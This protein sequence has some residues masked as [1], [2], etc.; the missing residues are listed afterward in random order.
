[1]ALM[2]PVGRDLNPRDKIK[3][4][5]A[6]VRLWHW[7]N[8]IAN[9]GLLLTVLIV[10]TVTNRYET[11]RLV[12]QELQMAKVS[13][14]NDQAKQVAQALGEGVWDVHVHFGYCL[15]GLLLFRLL[16]EAFQIA[17]QKLIRKIKNAYRQ[18]NIVNRNGEVDRHELAEMIIYVIFYILLIIQSVT[19]LSIT[20]ENIA[21]VKLNHSGI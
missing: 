11:S 21:F 8:A 5:S 10:S 6:S 1:M 3:K 19:G 7:T 17:D 2:E 4:H 20:F 14:N 16:L 9:S 15:A 18:L 13:I 12:I